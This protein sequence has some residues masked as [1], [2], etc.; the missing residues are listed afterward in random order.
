MPFIKSFWEE[1]YFCA[2][3]TFLQLKRLKHSKI[4]FEI[5]IETK[6]QRTF[7]RILFSSES[8]STVAF[9]D[10]FKWFLQEFINSP[11]Y[12]VMIISYEMFLRSVEE[13]RNTKFGL[14]ICDEAHRLKNTAIKTATVSSA[15]FIRFSV[16]FLWFRYLKYNVSAY[17][18]RTLELKTRGI[19]VC[20]YFRWFLGS[21]QSGGFFLQERRC[22]LAAIFFLSSHYQ[23]LS[24]ILISPWRNYP[25]YF[26]NSILINC[27]KWCRLYTLASPFSTLPCAR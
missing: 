14:V 21:R 1:I 3:Q 9:S 11:L 22:R 15:N 23:F 16:F 10:S 18:T 12:P 17:D 5:V 26:P 13:V 27:R 20:F 7:R 4:K 25:L 2:R 24:H 6:K 8:G 19:A